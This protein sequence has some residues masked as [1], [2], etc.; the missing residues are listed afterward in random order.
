MMAGGLSKS[1]GGI[2]SGTAE[3]IAKDVSNSFTSPASE[4][5]NY[6]SKHWLT[7]VLVIALVAVIV[8]LLYKGITG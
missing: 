4:I 5:T 3:K 1:L 8:M 6:I 2:V 7:W